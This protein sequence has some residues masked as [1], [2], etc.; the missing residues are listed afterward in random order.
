MLER[1]KRLFTIA[2][3]T[4]RIQKQLDRI[5]D[6]LAVPVFWLFGKTQSGKTSIVKYLTGADRAEIGKGYQPCTRFSSLYQF[7][8]P[9]AP[10]AMFLDT[11]G[12]DE[13]G[14]DPKEDL[15]RFNDEA[16]VIVG[17][18]KVM[19]HAQENV[20]K[21]LRTLRQ[22]Q[23]RRP[24][25]LVLTCLHEAYPQ[26]QHPTP[27]PFD[28]KGEPTEPTTP[29]VPEDLLRSVA[30]QRRRFGD[31]VDRVALVDLTP[32]EEGFN[33]PE[34][35]GLR[36]RQELLEVL[37]AAVGQ[38]L[39][40]LDEATH[41]LQDLYARE[42]LPHIVAYSSLAASA[43]A[44]PIPVLDLVLL[45]G[46]QSRMIYHL[47]RHYGQ[48]MTA[49]GFLEIAGGAGLGVLARQATRMTVVELLKMIPIV[50]SLAGAVAGGALA[51]ASTYALGKAF[52]YY[53]RRVHQ[54][55]VPQSDDLKQY[56]K[57][58]L[59]LAEQ[60]WKGTF[61]PKAKPAAEGPA[62]SA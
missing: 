23:R 3:R 50:G 18:V 35:G 25:V 47:A 61:G 27:Y 38:T 56:Y 52:C 17:V 20:L 7:P 4:N 16:H 30:E 44:V 9:E 41:E 54:G 31:L 11:R 43:G 45:S 53:Y 13:P 33:E 29:P 19:D 49:K 32:V 28:D 10:L 12:L 57:D 14:Y 55:H 39:R 42:A 2:D 22:A 26:Q 37:P 21:H 60:L 36:L 40:T 46:V 6:R 59:A 34:Y 24:V 62:A 48:P 1:F 5:R 51:W 8:T 15:D 58:Q